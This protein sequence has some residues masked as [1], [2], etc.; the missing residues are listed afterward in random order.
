MSINGIFTQMHTPAGAPFKLGEEDKLSF[1]LSPELLGGTSH[2][3]E[4]DLE[5][6]Q[7][8]GRHVIGS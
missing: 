6:E 5:Y 1:E 8:L 4:F 7:G 3:D 2:A